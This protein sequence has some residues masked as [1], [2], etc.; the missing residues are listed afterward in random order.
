MTISP[1]G[2][3]KFLIQFK[4]H[5]NF[6]FILNEGPF[7]I[8][9]TNCHK[10]NEIVLGGLLYV[11]NNRDIKAFAHFSRIY[12]ATKHITF[13]FLVK[14]TFPCN[15]HTFRFFRRKIIWIITGRLIFSIKFF[16]LFLKSDQGLSNFLVLQN[17]LHIKKI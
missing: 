12:K 9:K 3:D 4:I 5:L 14:K 1:K 15:L 2:D 11:F 10:I 17:P 6:F 7:K 8:I 13:T 16:F